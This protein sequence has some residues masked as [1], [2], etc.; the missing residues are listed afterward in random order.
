MGIKKYLCCIVICLFQIGLKFLVYRNNFLLSGELVRV[1]SAYIKNIFL[2]SEV[3]NLFPISYFRLRTSDFK[4][5][6]DLS[7]YPIL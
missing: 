5:Q 7:K 3:R 6:T 4:L 2:M 1:V